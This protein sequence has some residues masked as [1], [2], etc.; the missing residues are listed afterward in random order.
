MKHGG[1]SFESIAGRQLLPSWPL[2]VL[3][4]CLIMRNDRVS[5]A[6]VHDAVSIMPG[7]W[8]NG[9]GEKTLVKFVLILLVS[10]T[11]VETILH[12]VKLK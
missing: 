1:G 8:V 7:D 12:L 3:I 6:L 5:L 4:G 2:G 11:P 10:E 9:D